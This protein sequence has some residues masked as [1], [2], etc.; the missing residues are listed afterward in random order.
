[1][2]SKGLS[3]NHVTVTVQQVVTLQRISDL[4]CSALEGGLKL[5]VC[6]CVV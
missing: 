6:H 5:L 2:T 3:M 4:L 1:M